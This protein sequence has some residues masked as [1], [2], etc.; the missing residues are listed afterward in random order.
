MLQTAGPHY[1]DQ[2]SFLTVIYKAYYTDCSKINDKKDEN[3]RNVSENW[4]VPANCL[5]V[6]GSRAIGS[7]Q[8]NTR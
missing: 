1:P 8:H 2:D 4:R 5:L 6:H 7:S 3:N